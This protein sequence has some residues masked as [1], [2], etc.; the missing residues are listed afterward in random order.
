MRREGWGKEGRIF[1]SLLL[2]FQVL[3]RKI[4]DDPFVLFSEVNR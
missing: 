4:R 2:L 3:D 1:F